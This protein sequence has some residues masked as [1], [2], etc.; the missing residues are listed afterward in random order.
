MNGIIL[1]PETGIRQEIE[2]IPKGMEICVNEYNIRSANMEEADMALSPKVI[3]ERLRIAFGDESQEVIGSKLNMSQGNVSKLLSGLQ[4]PALDTLHTIS[5]KYDVSVDWILGLTEQKK[6]QSDN[7]ANTY[8]VAAEAVA[9]IVIKG[10]E[11]ESKDRKLNIS[12]SDPLLVRLINKSLVLSKTD[13]DLYADWKK[14]KLSMFDG[15]KLLYKYSW[16][17][18]SVD[19]LAS[20]ATIDSDWVE[21]LEEAY[22]R[23]EE[24]AE[25]MGDSPSPFGR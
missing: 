18:D 13:R 9:N 21:V 16:E 4:L 12:I 17:H 6:I 5:E 25:M 23:D 11:T 15:K 22:A 24:W 10:A 2:T 20:E 3:S 7:V 19:F 8:S 14:T 1:R